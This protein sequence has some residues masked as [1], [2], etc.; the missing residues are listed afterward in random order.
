MVGVKRK[1]KIEPVTESLYAVPGLTG[2]T[3]VEAKDKPQSVEHVRAA[4]IKFL[5]KKIRA[6]LAESLQRNLK[7]AVKLG[8]GFADI[9]VKN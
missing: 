1:G 6:P 5:V 2:K 4:G 3:H 9:H 7:A 8:T